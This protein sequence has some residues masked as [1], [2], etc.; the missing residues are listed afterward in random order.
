MGG[1]VNWSVVPDL[2]AV[3]ALACA[4]ASVTRRSPTPVSRLWLTGWLMIVLHFTAFAFLSLTGIA[5]IIAATTGMV[6]LS[7]A[8]LLFQTAS[9]PY[10]KESSARLTISMLFVLNTAYL[11]LCNLPHTHPG[12]MNVVAVLFGVTPLTI[13][14]AYHRRFNHPLRWINVGVHLTLGITLL[15]LQNKPVIGISLGQ[16]AAVFVVYLICCINFIYAYRRATAG[17]FITIAGFFSWAMVFVISPLI[18]LNLPQVSIEN[19]VWNL[20]KYVVAVGMILVLL[21]DQIEYNKFLA[22]HDELTNLPNRRL[23]QD[24]LAYTLERS[25]RSGDRMALLVIDLDHFKHVNDTLGHHI[26]DLLLQE[27]GDAFARRVRRSDTVARTGGDEFS[28]ILEDPGS[29]EDAEH[30]AQTLLQLLQEPLQLDEHTV[31]IGASVGVALFPD[32]AHDIESLRIAADMLMYRHKKA[33]HE[34]TSQK[35]AVVR[36]LNSDQKENRDVELGIIQS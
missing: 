22:L 16:N 36:K 9:I 25:R 30:V 28:I 34:L 31:Q 11:V 3:A 4:F 5:Q 24:R 7:W 19:D 12:A 2:I 1:P 21:E 23:F 29:R 27:V 6:A 13:M 18:A 14:L 26:G 10:R 8:G 35:A 33:S 15:I 32:D 17:A 20:P